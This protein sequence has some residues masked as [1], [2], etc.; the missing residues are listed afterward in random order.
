MKGAVLTRLKQYDK[1]ID[2]IDAAI[3]INP[4]DDW[5]FFF[6]G[7]NMNND[8]NLKKKLYKTLS[9]HNN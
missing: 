7:N 9:I 8:Y 5:P 4:K 6:K 2:Y 3:E 1:A